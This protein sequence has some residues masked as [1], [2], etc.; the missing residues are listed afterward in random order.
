MAGETNDPIPKACSVTARSPNYRHELTVEP[1][2]S[3]HAIVSGRQFDAE[4]GVQ[5]G[6]NKPVS[7]ETSAP[8]AALAMVEGWRELGRRDIQMKCD[9]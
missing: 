3:N 2:G 7:F 6:H 4:T 8:K 9:F 1:V 5:T